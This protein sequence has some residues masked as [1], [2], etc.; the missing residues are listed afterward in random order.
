MKKI[1]F[2]CVILALFVSALSAAADSVWMPMDDY[3]MTTWDPESDNTCEYQERP[4]Y[5]AAGAKGYVT[6]V[7]TPLDQTPVK[8]YPNGTLFKVTFV[9]GKGNNQWGAIEAVSLIG[10]TTFTEDWTGESGYVAFKDLTRGYD[11]QVFIDE[12]I[13]ELAS[14]GKDD[15]DLCSGKEFVLWTAPNSGKQL[16]YVTSDYISYM[17]MDFSEDIPAEY[18]MFNFGAF[19]RDPDGNR[20]V[21]A[22]L[23]QSW[24][25][26]WFC[27]DKMTDGGIKPVY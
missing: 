3:F 5:L 27:L 22:R 16:E 14:F 18:R 4:L 11:Y 12:H 19:Y 9:C 6:A 7:K 10:E 1:T 25:H 13:K 26:G 2:L 24:E 20:W 15:Y 23:R 8:T 21:E 17:C